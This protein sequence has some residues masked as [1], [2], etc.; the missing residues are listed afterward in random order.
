MHKEQE[1]IQLWSHDLV[2]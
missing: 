2:L 1:Y